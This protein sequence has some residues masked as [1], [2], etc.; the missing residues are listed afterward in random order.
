MSRARRILSS[1]RP[2]RRHDDA[3]GGF[4][5]I[6]VI[7]ALGLLLA[8]MATTAGFFTTS[9]KQSNGQT[10]AQEAAV[11]ADQ[12]LDYTRSVAGK[13]LLTGPHPGCRRCDNCQPAGRRRPQ[14]GHHRH[15]ATTTR[16]RRGAATQA[17]PITLNATVSGTE[18]HRHDLH[19]PV[20][21]H[22][23][24]PARTCTTTVTGIRLALPHHRRRDVLARRRARLR[25]QQALLLR[26]EHAARP[27][28]RPVL[29]RERRLRRLLHLAAHHHLVH[30]EHRHDR[31]RRPPSR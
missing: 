10:Q 24:R 15:A 20:L 16:P 29:Q 21:P 6:E 13:S 12:Q 28:Q 23:R 31:T 4:S 5:L 27:G 11:L 7:V 14:P 18:V 2:G 19:R 1:F 9:L 25:E 3:D 26:G 17:V 8:V 22:R 30:P